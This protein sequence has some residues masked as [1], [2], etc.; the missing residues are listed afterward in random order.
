[1]FAWFINI[2]FC[3]LGRL[4]R[5]DLGSWR[6]ADL[7]RSLTLS[8]MKDLNALNALGPCGGFVSISCDRNS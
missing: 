4:E 1:M 5:A 7:W 6:L 8:L 2:D 3:L